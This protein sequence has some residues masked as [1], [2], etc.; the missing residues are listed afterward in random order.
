[1][2]LLESAGTPP[3]SARSQAGLQAPTA[4]A[5][6]SFAAQTVQRQPVAALRPAPQKV[7][8]STFVDVVRNWVGTIHPLQRRG[9][10]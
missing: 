2:S 10:E 6:D 4:P 5:A 8:V 1:M 3:V 7:I 9:I